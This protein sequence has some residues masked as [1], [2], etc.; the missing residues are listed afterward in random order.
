MERGQVKKAG[1]VL[2]SRHPRLPAVCSVDFSLLLIRIT[3]PAAHARAT[4]SLSLLPLSLH[5]LPTAMATPH[6]FGYLFVCSLCR[7]C[8]VGEAMIKQPHHNAGFSFARIM[9]HNGSIGSLH[10]LFINSPHLYL[11]RIHQLLTSQSPIPQNMLF[12]NTCFS[13]TFSTFVVYK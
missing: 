4:F 12:V 1:I 13:E 10:I 11:C 3:R 8:C 9:E 5:A 2:R 6:R 7:V